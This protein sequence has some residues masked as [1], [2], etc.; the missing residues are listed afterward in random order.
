MIDA[1]TM[2][3]RIAAADS[4]TD[5]EGLR[6]AAL[7][8]SGSVTALLKSLGAMDPEARAGEAPKIHALREAVT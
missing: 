2:L 6:V 3:D 8:K 5:L 4:L 1:E 7:G